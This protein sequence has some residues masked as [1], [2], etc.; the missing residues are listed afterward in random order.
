MSYALITGASKGIGREIAIELA[1]RKYDIFLVARSE[2]LLTELSTNIIKEHGVKCTYVA[3]DLT[4]D[5]GIE[6]VVS[7]FLT[8]KSEL[9]ILV[10]NAGYGLWGSFADTSLEETNS[11]IRINVN[12]PVTLSYRLIPELKKSKQSYILNIAST[13][14]YQAVPKLAVY[15]ACKSFMILFS[16]GLRYELRKTNISVTCVSPG[17]TDTNFMDAAGMHSEHIRKKADKVKM[18]PSAVARFAVK[19]MFSKKAEAIPGWINKI[20]VALIPF[21]PKALTEKIAAGIY[22]K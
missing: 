1:R 2:N 17:T 6:K 11:L 14:A 10:N 18:T 20:S 16:R 4:T 21:T 13:T 19:S 7:T 8:L 15:A 3:A 5:S 12:L 22:E 9:S